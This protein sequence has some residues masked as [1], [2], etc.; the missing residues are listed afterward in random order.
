MQRLIITN[1]SGATHAI[2]AAG[3]DDEI[4]TWDDVLHDGPVPG[5]RVLKSPLLESLSDVR[6]EF[7]ARSGW[8]SYK[9]IREK[10]RQ[11]DNRFT[12]AMNPLGSDDTEIVLWFEHDLYDQLQL[13]QILSLLSEIDVDERRITLIC[14]DH[15]I[16]QSN[17][18]TLSMD[19]ESRKQVIT[20]QVEAAALMWKAFTARSPVALV[21][22]SSASEFSRMPYLPNALRRWFEEFP[23]MRDG[24]S[25]TERAILNC[26]KDGAM[27]GGDLF[28]CQQATE[29]AAFM[30]DA[31]FWNVLDR[32]MVDGRELVTAV[33]PTSSSD[34]DAKAATTY[35]LTEFALRV[36]ENK[37]TATAE[38]PAKWMG[39]VELTRT[40]PW[41][42]NAKLHQFQS[43]VDFT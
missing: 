31:S 1:G 34:D 27:K 11:R 33:K 38:I 20:F 24:L 28:H 10:F 37:D 9:A 39:G 17:P 12:Q 22:L 3:L 29:E 2:R 42:W 19:F 5:E 14:H 13:I 7:I 25:R 43:T 18:E 30:G 35:T 40:N 21:E 6:A 4:L 41:Y 8:G 16:A 23:D 36:L 26:L 15:F 32:M